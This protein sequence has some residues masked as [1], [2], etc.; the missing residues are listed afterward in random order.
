MSQLPRMG[1][2]I[3]PTRYAER[4]HQA[5]RRF[6]TASRVKIIIPQGCNMP[7]PNPCNTRNGMSNRMVGAY[8]RNNEPKVNA[9]TDVMKSRLVPNLSAAQPVTG[10]TV[11]SAGCSR[12]WS[13]RRRRHSRVCWQRSSRAGA[14]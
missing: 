12:L 1:P 6:G 8:A 13:R 3:G 7:P 4:G 11:A 2:P 5:T 14:E 9:S 10:M